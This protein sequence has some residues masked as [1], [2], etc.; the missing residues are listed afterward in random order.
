MKINQAEI[1]EFL[2][3]Y[4]AQLNRNFVIPHEIVINIQKDVHDNFDGDEGSDLRDFIIEDYESMLL[5]C[6]HEDYSVEDDECI[7]GVDVHGDPQYREY[8]YKICNVCGATCPI[9]GVE[10]TGEGEYDEITGDW[11]HEN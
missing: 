3:D 8:R 4:N 2:E 5:E 1:K 10:Q 7:T 6:N 9:Y 11:E